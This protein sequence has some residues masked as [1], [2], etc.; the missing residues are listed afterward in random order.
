MKTKLLMLA[1]TA[2]VVWGLKRTY[3][4]SRADDLQ[5]ILAPTARLVGAVTGV[6]FVPSPGEGYVSHARLFLIEKSCAG[7]N[8]MAAAFLVLVLT[9]FRRATSPGS[10]ALV[11]IG[12]LSAAYV[13]AVMVNATRIAV[14]LWLGTPSVPLSISAAAEVHRIEG[15]VVYFAGLTLLYEVARRL[16]RRAVTVRSQFW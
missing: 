16:N 4:D 8:F 9:L 11:L 1:V 15:I 5:W 10:V 6:Q 12:S 7:I 14:A 13:A 3:A 2:L